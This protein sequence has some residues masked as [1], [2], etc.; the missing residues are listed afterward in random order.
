[1]ALFRGGPGRLIIMECRATVLLS[2]ARTFSSMIAVFRPT[3]FPVFF[4]YEVR[5]LIY[6]SALRY[7]MSLGDENGDYAAEGKPLS[8]HLNNVHA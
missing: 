5:Q 2:I 8:K 4:L 6:S 7:V 1:M 3:V